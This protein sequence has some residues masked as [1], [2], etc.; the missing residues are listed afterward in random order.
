[1]AF[2]R[3]W[4][5]IANH[6]TAKS[7]LRTGILLLSAIEHVHTLRPVSG[8]REVDLGAVEMIID[9]RDLQGP[10]FLQGYNISDQGLREELP[11]LYITHSNVAHSFRSL[12]P[13][14]RVNR[15][16]TCSQYY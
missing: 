13:K 14:E 8:G 5:N 9:R 15:E 11:Q 10:I 1:M 4:H 6:E 7:C 12:K 3:E 16:Y 2:T